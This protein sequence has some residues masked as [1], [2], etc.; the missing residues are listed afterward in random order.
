[1]LHFYRD[2]LK[3]P[4]VI[5][6]DWDVGSKD[7]DRCVGLTDSACKTALLNAGNSYI[8]IF[9]Y[10]NPVGA[11]PSQNR[12]AC[13]AGI[14]HICFDVIDVAEEY[15]RLLAAGVPF[16]TAPVKVGVFHTTYGRDPDGNIFEL[17]EIMGRGVPQALTN[18]AMPA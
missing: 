1:M 6:Y 15:E 14:T 10:L 11:E 3:L 7:S 16:H 18:L 12:R 13:D 5:S 4:F 17:Q 2:L 8:E 9:E